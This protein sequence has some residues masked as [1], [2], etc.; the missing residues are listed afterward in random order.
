MPPPT[1]LKP[2]MTTTLCAQDL[3][4]L[5]DQLPAHTQVLSLDCFDT[6]LWRKVVHPTDVFFSLQNSAL[7][8]A[9][10]LTA[11]MRA[12]SEGAARK[13]R[14]LLADTYEVSLS[15]IYREMMPQADESLIAQ[16]VAAEVDCEIAHGFIYEPVARL[17]QRARARGLRVIVV[18]DTYLSSTQLR[19]MLSELMGEGFQN[20]HHVYCSSD[21]GKA[22]TTGIWPEILRREKRQPKQLFHLG[23]NLQADHEAPARLGIGSA[24]LLNHPSELSTSL[25]GRASAALQIMPE[26]RHTHALPNHFHAQLAAHHGEATGTAAQIGYQSLGPVLYNFAHFITQELQALQAGGA[27]VK[28]AFLLRDGYMPA[29]ACEPFL[30]ENLS[31]VNVSRFT[32][33]AASLRCKDDVVQL[34]AGT[35]SKKSMPALLR[36]LLLPAQ[37]SKQILEKAHQAPNVELEFA[38]LVLRDDTLKLVFAQS[39]AFRER[40]FTHVKQRT[41]VVAGDTL[42]LVDLGYSGTVQNRLRRVFRDELGVELFGLYLISK[43]TTTGASDRKGLIDEREVDGRLINALTAYIGLFEMMC[44][45]DQPSTEDYTATGDPVHAASAPPCPQ[46]AVVQDIQEAGL[47]FVKDALATPERHRPRISDARELAQQTAADIARL[48]YF[49]SAAEIECLAAFEF[50]FNLGTDLLLPTADLEAGVAEYRR[51]GFALMNRDFAGQRIGY[52]LEM[53][54]MDISLS[55]TLLSQQRFGYGIKPSEASFRHE[56][57]PTLIAN[58]AQYLQGS[59]RAHATSDGFFSL[60]LPMSASFDLSVLWGQRYEWLQLDSIQRVPLDNPGRGE[61]LPLGEAVFLDGLEQVEG[62]LVKFSEAGM[63]YFPASGQ[64]DHGRY[65]IRVVFRPV[66]ARTVAASQSTPLALAAAAETGPVSASHPIE[67]HA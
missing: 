9:H 30:G 37:K 24:W 51:E 28:V 6:L 17:I 61:D 19:H 46:A 8:Q 45:M 50:E 57:V 41:G 48:V 67:E 58:Q 42:V 3:D 60:H 21:V 1:L 53:R 15:D 23:D 54:Y 59:E 2:P 35:L 33:I 31:Q 63:M 27:R 7:F 40:L 18:S 11:G 43:H 49:P 47:R 5:L 16:A 4:G 66:L 25:A 36:Q 34:L 32:S 14:K 22:K 56:T 52:P 20:I 12:N 10:G 44:S 29:R 62:T 39:R 55:T 26:L 38:R 65:M 64:Q 13:K